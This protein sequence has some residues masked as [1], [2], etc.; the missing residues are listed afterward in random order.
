MR[1]KSA[2]QM[3]LNFTSPS[4]AASKTARLSK[5]TQ[6][7]DRR[8]RVY[9]GTESTCRGSVEAL[10]L[11]GVCREALLP[12]SRDLDGPSNEGGNRSA[13]NT[14]EKPL[15]PLSS[16]SFPRKWESRTRC[17]CPGNED[18]SPLSRG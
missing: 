15:F 14:C 9:H 8:K 10:V 16:S 18:G 2:H 5:P 1:T 3:Y 13:R 4:S 12:T 6:F 7:D 11:C 17:G